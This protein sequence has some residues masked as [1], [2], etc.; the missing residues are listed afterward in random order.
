M[1]RCDN[2]PTPGCD[3]N[4]QRNSE[5]SGGAASKLAKIRV[6]HLAEMISGIPGLEGFFCEVSTWTVSTSWGLFEMVG[7]FFFMFILCGIFL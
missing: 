3:V 4:P 6:G 5:V 7:M 1:K 2:D